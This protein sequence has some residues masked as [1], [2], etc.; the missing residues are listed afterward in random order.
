MVFAYT[1]AS[2]GTTTYANATA[3]RYK[4]IFNIINEDDL[5]PQL[6]MSAWGFT[7]YGVNKPGS[8][9]NSYASDWDKLTGKTY[10]HAE[11]AQTQ[12]LTKLS[13]VSND[14]NSCYVFPAIPVHLL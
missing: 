3:D 14:R 6:P 7:R 11:T 12:V 9:E 2:P 1:F 8:I 4:S 10:A 5:V 13:A